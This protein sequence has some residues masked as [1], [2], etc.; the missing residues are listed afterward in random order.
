MRIFT[1]LLVAMGLLA[2][3]GMAEEPAT[4]AAVNLLPG[5]SAAPGAVQRLILAHALRAKA[6]AGRDALTALAAARLA[7][8]IVLNAAPDLV[9]DPAPP[10][11]APAPQASAIPLPEAIFDLARDLAAGD[12]LLLEMIE[13]EES[14]G[15]SAPP[16]TANRA[17][18]SL[19]PGQS[20]TWRIALFGSDPAEIGLIGE[21]ALG[22]TLEVT[23]D[24]Q[25]PVCRAPAAFDQALCAFVPARNGFF[26]ATVTNT[27]AMAGSYWLLTN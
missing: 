1:P 9:P 14:Q 8:G 18:S 5:K 3:I 4:T 12:D 15:R 25:H 13:R 26:N 10:Q 22:L 23:D 21:S 11:P 7:Q 2:T 27:G 19:A 24:S 16:E 17:L 6:V 20:E